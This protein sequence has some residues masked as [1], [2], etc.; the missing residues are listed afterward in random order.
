MKDTCDK[1]NFRTFLSFFLPIRLNLRG[2][3]Q[4]GF[5]KQVQEGGGGG[6]VE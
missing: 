1:I 5:G 6:L 4:T 3:H 2:R